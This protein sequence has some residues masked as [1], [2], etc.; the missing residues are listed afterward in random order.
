MAGILRGLG[1]VNTPA[2]TYGICYY[3][4][5]LPSAILLTFAFDFGAEGLCLSFFIGTGSAALVFT[6]VLMRVDYDELIVA[7]RKVV[8]L[9]GEHT[10]DFPAASSLVE[11]RE[12]NVVNAQK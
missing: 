10:K 1:L 3:L 11:A 8:T 6:T 12:S 9:R 2:T 4:I 5:M 7:A